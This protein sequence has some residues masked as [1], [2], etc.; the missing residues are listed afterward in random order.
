MLIFKYSKLMGAEY[1]SHLDALRHIGKTLVRAKIPVEFSKGFNPHLQIYLSP[2]VY[3]GLKSQSEYCL[4]ETDFEAKDFAGRFNAYSPK[5]IK[6][7]T[8]FDVS[9]K[10]RIAGLINGAKYVFHC[11]RPFDVNYVL[12]SDELPIE[13]KGVVKNEREKVIDLKFLDDNRL[14]ATLA[15]GNDV[16]RADLFQNYIEEKFGVKSDVIK[17]ESNIDGKLPEEIL[18]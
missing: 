8:A 2:P 7:I 13:K 12:D 3:V 1:I 14:I 10:H 15:F 18:N 6:C 17:V 11:D 16:L 4:V 5:G 9:V